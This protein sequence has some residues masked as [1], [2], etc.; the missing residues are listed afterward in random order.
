MR[1]LATITLAGLAAALP[2][3]GCTQAL[4]SHI[5]RRGL[6]PLS[7]VK[8]KFYESEVVLVGEVLGVRET[9]DLVAALIP[10]VQQSGVRVL[11]SEFFRTSQQGI[12]DQLV[13]SPAFDE[14]V[15]VAMLRA[16]PWP[17]CGYREHV[18]VVRAVWQSNRDRKL[19]GMRLV[20][21]DSDWNQAEQARE[22]S[23]RKRYAVIQ[24]REDHMVA[25]LDAVLHNHT[26]VLA[27]VSLMNS[28]LAPGERFGARIAQRHRAFQV[29]VHHDPVPGPQR[30]RLCAEIEAAV[31][32]VG[33]K[34]IAFDLAGSPVATM[35]DER[36]PAFRMLGAR[37][38]LFDL[39]R[40]WVFQKPAAELTP[41]QWIE[42]LAPD[43]SSP[44]AEAPDPRL[45]NVAGGR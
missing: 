35:R 9:C 4:T 16:G 26:K 40:G 44:A 28:V 22:T 31:A 41:V 23:P 34:P 12:L 6:E 36:A 33:K 30:S 10:V 8:R 37:A 43:G 3:Q 18:E 17:A 25:T 29:V 42:G 32:A 13:V 38:G 21:L 39:A 24:A 1:A 14:A 5:K 2:G 7:Y 15:V 45:G 20:G 19:P 27:H 11:A